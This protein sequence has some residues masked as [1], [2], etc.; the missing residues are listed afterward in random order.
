LSFL[1]PKENLLG[2]PNRGFSQHLA[3]LE[4]GRLSIAAVCV[5]AAQA[6]LDESLRYA[7]ERISVLFT[8]PFPWFG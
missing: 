4:T 7:R 6:C 1:I 3:V 8:I 5:G 2:D